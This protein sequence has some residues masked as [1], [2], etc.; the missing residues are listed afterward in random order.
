MS[1]IECNLCGMQFDKEDSLLYER[2]Q[3]HEEFHKP[4]PIELESGKRRNTTMGNVEWIST[5]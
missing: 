4:S 1:K 5:E 3:R 2:M